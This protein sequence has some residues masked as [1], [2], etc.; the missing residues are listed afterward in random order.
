MR[1]QNDVNKLNLIDKKNT[2]RTYG[3]CLCRKKATERRMLLNG[4]FFTLTICYPK[5]P[6]ESVKI[7]LAE[8]IFTAGVSRIVAVLRPRILVALYGLKNR[9]HQIVG[10]LLIAA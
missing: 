9:L 3:D 1:D 2:N 10:A 7:L 6:A 5:T 4:L 8:R